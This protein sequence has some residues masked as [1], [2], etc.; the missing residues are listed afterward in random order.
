V[1]PDLALARQARLTGDRGPRRT[2]GRDPLAEADGRDFDTAWVG[3]GPDLATTAQAQILAATGASAYL[4]ATARAD[5]MTTTGRPR[6]SRARS[7][8]STR[9]AAPSTGCST[10]P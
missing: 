1:Q 8:G 2:A 6:C 7:P 5:G 4:A 9:P 3:V 10:A